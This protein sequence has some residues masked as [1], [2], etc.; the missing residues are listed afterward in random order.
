MC[1]IYLSKFKLDL[2][3]LVKSYKKKEKM[4]I[5]S[6][7]KIVNFNIYYCDSRITNNLLTSLIIL[8]NKVII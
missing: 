1:I 4:F 7:Y 3:K 5:L 2:E 8:F 6:K